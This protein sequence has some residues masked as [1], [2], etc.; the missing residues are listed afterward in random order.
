MNIDSHLLAANS[1]KGSIDRLDLPCD[2]NIDS[3]LSSRLRRHLR[4]CYRYRISRYV[5]QYRT[6]DYRSI[7]LQYSVDD[8][9]IIGL[10]DS[11]YGSA[12]RINAD[13]VDEEHPVCYALNSSRKP[14]RNRIG[15]LCCRAR[16]E[17]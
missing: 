15:I 7:C 14:N 16:D 11:I 9:N 4:W 13:L 3:R 8:D 17:C 10:Q 1:K 6:R 12:G 2:R 5:S